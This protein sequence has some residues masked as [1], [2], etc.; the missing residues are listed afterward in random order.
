MRILTIVW[1]LLALT[2]CVPERPTT[3]AAMTVAANDNRAPAGTLHGGVLSLSLEVTEGTWQP[4]RALPAL[5]VLA[6]AETGKSATTPGPLIRVARGTEVRVRITNRLGETVWMHGL[7]DRPGQVEAL[8]ID[9]HATVEAHFSADTPGS[10]Y[11]FGSLHDPAPDAREDR[12][13]ELH[14]A[15]IVDTG[16]TVDDD[17]VFVI[18]FHLDAGKDGPAFWTINGASWPDTERLTYLVGDRVRWRWINPTT[19][20]HPMHLHGHYFTVTSSGDNWLDRPFAPDGRRLA[21]TQVLDAGETM[22]L[23]WSPQTPGNWLFH[24]HI[25]FHVMPENRLSDATQW[26]DDYAELPHDQHMAGLVLG[27]HVLPATAA[28]AAAET[29]QAPRR[30]ALRIGDR[31]GAAYSQQGMPTLKIPRLGYA[32]DGGPI[33]APGTALV[34]ERGQP[35]EITIV[36]QIAHAS[37]VHWHGIE[38]DSYYDGV[39]HWGGDS[40]RTTPLIGPGETFTA[41]FA[42]PRAGTFMYHTHFNDFFQLVGGLY[43]ALI[44]VD[45]GKPFDAATDHVYVISMDGPDD[46]RD[47]ALLNGAAELPAVAWHV[48]QRQRLRL[49]GI[50]PVATA[51]IRLMHEQTSIAWRALAK[52]GADLP[53]ALATPGIADLAISPGETYDF[54]VVP[55]APGIL[56]LEA[57][58]SGSAGARAGQTINV[59][60]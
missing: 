12:D 28:V 50:A 27:M 18:S 59:L 37:A 9:A 41:R 29:A 14:G 33:S 42:P 52:D 31:S 20:R 22:A 24:C 8:Q 7:N 13:S 55:D 39:P 54:D 5:K 46:L 44:V 35:V 15:L 2:G 3:T 10:Y 1:L 40:S 19:H 32:V 56:R 49:I 16:K 11:Y 26:Y 51:R 23:E 60:P 57:E 58:M 47:A 21:V 4:D 45:P 34:L 36:N 17:R 53:A 30:I 25:A 38:L 6:F 43:G 48:G